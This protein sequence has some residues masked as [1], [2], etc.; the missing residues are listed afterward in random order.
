MLSKRLRH[1]KNTRFTGY[2]RV[3]AA[4]DRLKIKRA[5]LG[6]CN[7]PSVDDLL[8]HFMPGQ[9]V[10]RSLLLKP[11]SFLMST[12]EPIPTDYI[13]PKGIKPMSSARVSSGAQEKKFAGIEYQ[14]KGCQHHAYKHH[15]DVIPQSGML[16]FSETNKAWNKIPEALLV[17]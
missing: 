17:L 6:I 10:I 14:T 16:H 1:I 9:H 11:D 15:P 5:K 2:V 4:V 8:A 13:P 7:M 12:R 3:Q